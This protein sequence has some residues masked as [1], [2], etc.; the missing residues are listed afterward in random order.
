MT[1]NDGSACG[2]L[3]QGA[4]IWLEDINDDPAFSSIVDI[5]RETGFRAVQS[6]PLTASGTIIGMPSTHFGSPRKWS[7]DEKRQTAA[8]ANRVG[9]HL[10]GLLNRADTPTAGFGR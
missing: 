5:A 1:A 10:A 2:A 8:Y 3:A 4:S 9:N 6:T 7:F